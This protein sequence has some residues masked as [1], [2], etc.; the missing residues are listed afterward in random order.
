MNNTQLNQVLS[1]LKQGRSITQIDAIRLFNCYRLSA[2]IEKLR[3]Q[4]C[5]IVTYNEPNLNN[6]GR[7]ARYELINQVAA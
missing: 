6:K 2:I 4:G 5:D 1:H 3:R 7:H